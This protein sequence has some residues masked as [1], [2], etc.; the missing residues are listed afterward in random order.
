MGEDE[1]QGMDD[2]V[3]EGKRW[4]M[5]FGHKLLGKTSTSSFFSKLV[6]VVFC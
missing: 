4:Q 6:Q 3:A 5:M 2:L 1:K